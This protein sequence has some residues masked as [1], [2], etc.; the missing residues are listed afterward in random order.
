MADLF[1]VRQG[2]RTGDN[3]AFLLDEAA[4]KALPGRERRYFRRAIMSDP[5]L[6][7]EN[8]GYLLGFLSLR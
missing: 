1:Q 4:L 5:I 7:G 3:T 8:S 2:V 6:D